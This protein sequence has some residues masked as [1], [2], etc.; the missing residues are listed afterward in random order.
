MLFM[1]VL[2]LQINY[3]PV[4]WERCYVIER[5]LQACSSSESSFTEE[6]HLQ[7]IWFNSR[8]QRVGGVGDTGWEGWG[9]GWHCMQR[10]GWQIGTKDKGRLSE[11]ESSWKMARQLPCPGER[12]PVKRR[13]RRPLS[14]PLLELTPVVT[15]RSSS[16]FPLSQLTDCHSQVSSSALS[17]SASLHTL[18]LLKALTKTALP[19]EQPKYWTLI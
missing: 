3:S 10:W 17:V 15:E 12:Q 18:S 7:S 16:F 19:F 11:R 13:R 9:V 8:W 5:G 4:N 14:L 6:T 1:Y 2:G